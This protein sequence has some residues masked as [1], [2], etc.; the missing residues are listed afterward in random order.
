MQ[1]I[2]YIRSTPIFPGFEGLD[3]V[4]VFLLF[5]YIFWPVVVQ[6]WL[7]DA[8]QWLQNAQLYRIPTKFRPIWTIIRKFRPIFDPKIEGFDLMI[9]TSTGPRV[10]TLTPLTLGWE[11]TVFVVIP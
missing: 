11:P 9:F 8:F 3:L 10:L 4:L 2:P 1:W 5:S 6:I 7:W